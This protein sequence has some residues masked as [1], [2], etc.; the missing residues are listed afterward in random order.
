M[1]FLDRIASENIDIIKRDKFLPDG[2]E[3]RMVLSSTIDFFDEPKKISFKKKAFY[4][5]SR[6]L[7]QCDVDMHQDDA[8]PEIW[9]I[10]KGKMIRTTSKF[11]KES[12]L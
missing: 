6:V 9:K 12:V 1:N 11:I 3:A 4:P 10:S 7:Q 2:H 5:I 8:A